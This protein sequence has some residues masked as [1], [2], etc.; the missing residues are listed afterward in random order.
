MDGYPRQSH[1]LAGGGPS[2]RG[3]PEPAV[4]GTH[5]PASGTEAPLGEAVTGALTMASDTRMLAR[6]PATRTRGALQQSN[7]HMGWHPNSTQ[8]L[9]RSSST[10][11]TPVPPLLA[12]CLA[13]GRLLAEQ[14]KCSL[15]V[16]PRLAPWW[17]PLQQQGEA[18]GEGLGAEPAAPAALSAAATAAPSAAARCRR[19]R[20]RQRRRGG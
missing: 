13:E 2:S 5:L 9:L 1:G 11:S 19:G 15:V 7:C 20:K 4:A 6:Q 18:Q 14:F 12:T 10:S 3:D 16:V 8:G 17:D